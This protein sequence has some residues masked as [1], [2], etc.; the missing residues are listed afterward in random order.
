VC[1]LVFVYVVSSLEQNELVAIPHPIR[2]TNAGVASKRSFSELSWVCFCCFARL[3]C[4]TTDIQKSTAANAATN[5]LDCPCGWI[6]K[7]CSPEHTGDALSLELPTQPKQYQS[8]E[9]HAEER[10]HE[11]HWNDLG[12]KWASKEYKHKRG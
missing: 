7:T 9:T 5:D 6:E 4:Y 1:F 10:Q 3:I 12:R 8:S 2:E 11:I